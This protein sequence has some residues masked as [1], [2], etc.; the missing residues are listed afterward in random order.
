MLR[1]ARSMTDELKVL[2]VTEAFG[3][4]VFE[5]VRT[6]ANAGAEAGHSVHVAHSIRPWTPDDFATSFDSRIS[7]HRLSWGSRRNPRLLARGTTDLH[8]LLR[9]VPW[10]VVHFHSTFAGV[11]GAFVRPPRARTV[12]SP[13]GYAFLMTSASPVTRS[14]ARIA[15]IGVARRIQLIGAVSEAEGLEARRLGA[16]RVEVIHNGISELDDLG[17]MDRISAV[18]SGVVAAG[19]MAP[20]RQ[21]QRLPGSSQDFLKT[22]AGH[23]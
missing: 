23:G 11:A 18:R 13:H 1:G 2:H 19:R 17:H 7:L 5:T 12:Y 21:P 8:R 14:L 10:D 15:E 4:G 22:L 20:Q 16:R 3:S 6:I 9:E